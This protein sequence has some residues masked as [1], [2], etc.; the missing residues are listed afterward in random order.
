MLFSVARGD[1]AYNPATLYGW[2]PVF[3]VAVPGIVRTPVQLGLLNDDDLNALEVSAGAPREYYPCGDLDLDG[4]VDD[5]DFLL[6]AELM[7]SHRGDGRYRSDADYDH[8]NAITLL[9]YQS[10]YACYKQANPPG[11]T[12]QHYTGP[13]DGT[14][15]VNP[16][17]P[18]GG[19]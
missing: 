1:A 9:D 11:A 3:G 17:S 15:K 13:P 5:V 2:P 6:F 19:H 16:P 8:D 14:L 18:G 10:W 4:D 7:G 12:G